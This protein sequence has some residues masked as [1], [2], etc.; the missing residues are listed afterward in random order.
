M[1]ISSNIRH[2]KDGINVYIKSNTYQVSLDN[3]VIA[4]LSKKWVFICF[5]KY[6]N[7][8]KSCVIKFRVR[9]YKL[10]C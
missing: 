3:P 10:K 8:S 5:G 7:K 1:K 9:E 2:T 4:L 6:H